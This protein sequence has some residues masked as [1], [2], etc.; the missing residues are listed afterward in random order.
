MLGYGEMNESY[1][2]IT[3]TIFIVSRCR[4]TLKNICPGIGSTH[5]PATAST[6]NMSYPML[7]LYSSIMCMTLNL[8]NQ[9][10]MKMS[11]FF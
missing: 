3:Y 8:I 9:K 7:S 4:N 1:S 10:S 6:F 5:C 11:F 2:N